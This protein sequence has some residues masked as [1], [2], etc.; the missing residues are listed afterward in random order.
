MQIYWLLILTIFKMICRIIS[1]SEFLDC[2]FTFMSATANAVLLM[3]YYCQ[4]ALFY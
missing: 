4:P 2:V 1:V 3:Q